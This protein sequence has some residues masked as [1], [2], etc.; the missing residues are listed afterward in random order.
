MERNMASIV[1][2]DPFGE[3]LDD[4]FKGFVVRPVASE[5]GEPVQRMKIDVTEQNGDYKVLAELPGVKKEDIQ[6]NI[7]GD[8]VSITAETRSER[9]TKDGERVLHSERYFGKVSRAFRL[10]QEIDESRAGAKFNDGV[11]ELTLPKKP[12]TAAKTLT[13][14]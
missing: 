8:Q 13:I 9:D 4:F 14:Q 3:L 12:S 5:L 7:D 2:Y 10:G 1:R 11:L 6:I